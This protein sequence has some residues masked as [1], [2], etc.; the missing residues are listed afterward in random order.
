[1]NSNS[2]I[3]LLSDGIFNGRFFYLLTWLVRSICCEDNPLRRFIIIQKGLHLEQTNAKFNIWKLNSTSDS[4]HNHNWDLSWKP[5]NIPHNYDSTYLPREPEQ[6]FHP[7]RV[8]E[9]MNI[10]RIKLYMSHSMVSCAEFQKDNSDGNYISPLWNYTL[11][12]KVLAIRL[13]FCG[14]KTTTNLMWL[15]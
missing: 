14:E 6:L 8:S 5:N 13:W 9:P 4:E 7:L 10:W 11:Y 3:S 15:H 12:L 1:M 2:A